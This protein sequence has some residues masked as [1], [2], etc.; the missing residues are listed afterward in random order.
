MLPW[1]TPEWMWKRI[2]VS[3]LNFVSN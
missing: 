3:P 1:S 2:E